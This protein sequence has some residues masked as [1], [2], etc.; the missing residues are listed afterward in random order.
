MSMHRNLQHVL[1][2]AGIQEPNDI[3]E[4]DEQPPQIPRLDATIQLENRG[5]TSQESAQQKGYNGRIHQMLLWSQQTT[6]KNSAAAKLRSIGRITEAEKLERCHTIYTVAQ[7]SKCQKVQK[8][9][10]RCDLFYCAECQPRLSADRRKA[11]EWWT[12]TI[13]QPKHVVLTLKNTPDLTRGHKNE[14]LKWFNNLRRRKFAR[15]WLGGFYRIEVTNE[16]RGWH[17]HLHALINAHWIDEIE[18]SLQWQ[19]VTNGFGRIVRVRDCRQRSYLEEVTKYA[20]KGAQ[21]AAWLPDQIATFIDAFDGAKTFGVFGD[22]YG[23]RTEFAEWF[24]AVRDARPGCPCGCNELH[25]F[26]E[27]QFL[28][29]DFVATGNV[30]SIPPPKAPDTNL[31]FGFETTPPFGP[32]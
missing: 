13:A 31:T 30:E 16:G 10:N 19:D 6:H 14:L 7:C 1:A 21:L 29:K 20:V 9:P 3:Y 4:V 17:L 18:L 12:K 24:K 23:K 27:A 25:Y 22:L 8:F 28:E 2:S 15:N 5:T 26:T 11:V 32:R